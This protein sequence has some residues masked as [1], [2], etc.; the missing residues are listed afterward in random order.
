MY[1][2]VFVYDYIR[3][4][5][6]EKAFVGNNFNYFNFYGFR[7]DIKQESMNDLYTAKDHD[8]NKNQIKSFVIISG[9]LL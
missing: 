5:N 6:N 4:R 8:F 3:K 1:S 2:N 7:A 9:C